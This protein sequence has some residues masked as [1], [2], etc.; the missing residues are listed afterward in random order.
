MPQESIT[1]TLTERRRPERSAPA[2]EAVQYTAEKGLVVPLR[3][4]IVRRWLGASEFFGAAAEVIPLAML[5]WDITNA[6]W[7][8]AKANYS[9]GCR[10]GLS[11]LTH[12]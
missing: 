2:S 3:S 7:E 5:T 6:A 12:P 4:S 9:G 11:Y 8:T 10:P 1:Q